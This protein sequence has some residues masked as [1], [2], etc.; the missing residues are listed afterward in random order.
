MLLSDSGSGGGRKSRLF[1][2]PECRNAFLRVADT[3]GA[4]AHATYGENI[5]LLL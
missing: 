1:D 5:K 2:R 3:A 4:N